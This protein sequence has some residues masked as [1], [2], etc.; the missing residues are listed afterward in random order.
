MRV[1]SFLVAIGVADPLLAVDVRLV[2][3]EDHVVVAIEE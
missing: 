1:Q 3:G 2:V